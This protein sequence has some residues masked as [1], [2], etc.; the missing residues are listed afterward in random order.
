MK[1]K[2]K[3]TKKNGPAQPIDAGLAEMLYQRLQATGAPEVGINFT[4][5]TYG[6]KVEV[7]MS[8][9]RKVVPVSHTLPT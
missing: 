6:V 9:D 1:R 5:P 3:R 2:S 4:V 7:R 8:W